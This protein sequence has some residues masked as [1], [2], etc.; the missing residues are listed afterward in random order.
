MEVAGEYEWSQIALDQRNHLFRRQAT[1]AAAKEW[2]AERSEGE[3]GFV[4]PNIVEARLDVLKT[5]GLLPVGFS[6]EAQHVL[7]AAV[8]Q[9]RALSG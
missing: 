7:A 4:P 1:E 8:P 2:Q 6:G 3:L 9:P 5:R